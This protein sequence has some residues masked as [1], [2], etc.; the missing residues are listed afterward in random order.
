MNKTEAMWAVSLFERYLRIKKFKNL[1]AAYLVGSLASNTFVDG[2]SDID[3]SIILSRKDIL[4]EDSIK[5]YISSQTGME[6]FFT[7]YDDLFPPYGKSPDK[8]MNVFRI[9]NQGK[10]I[11]GFIDLSKVRDPSKSELIDSVVSSYTGEHAGAWTVHRI[12]TLMRC[13]IYINSGVMVFPKRELIK[14]FCYDFPSYIST[15]EERFLELA[16]GHTICTPHMPDMNGLYLRLCV[17]AG[18]LAF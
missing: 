1:V 17:Y 3:I 12:W 8:I 18:N 2:L 15:E 10:L 4:A 11:Y 7:I 5:D 16:A 14:R 13:F 6:C 9:K